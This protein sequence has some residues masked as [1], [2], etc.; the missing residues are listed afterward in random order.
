MKP[1]YIPHKLTVG[2]IT[3]LSDSQSQFIISEGLHEIEDIIKVQTL[4]SVFKAIITDISKSSVEV[5]ILELLAEAP[6]KK[7]GYS[8][9]LLQ[10]LSGDRKFNTLLEKCVEIGVE[11]VIPI[12]T[13]YTTLDQ[14]EANKKMN[15]YRRIIKEAG[16]Q[17]RNPSPTVILEPINIS[18]LPELNFTDTH[19]ICLA[20]ENVGTI[21]LEEVVRN[22][23]GN[24]TIAVGPETGWSSEDI[25][26]MKNLG[27]QFVRLKG[28]ILRTE[29][30]GIVIASIISYLNGE[31]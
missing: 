23:P 1:Y 14:K 11:T 15:N 5:E 20:T 7:D 22:A 27:F 6:S 31:I 12:E 21:G 25:A 8:I 30:A 26:I 28:N 9:T 13:A 29:T 2:D 10:A 3:N 4:T 19:R 24:F 16:E 17:S 18:R